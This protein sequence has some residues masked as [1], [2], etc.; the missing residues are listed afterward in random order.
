MSGKLLDALIVAAPFVVG[1]LIIWLD[2]KRAE[3]KERNANR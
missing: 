1:V 3:R 2:G